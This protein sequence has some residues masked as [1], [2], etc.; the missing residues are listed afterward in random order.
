MGFIPEF[1][2]GNNGNSIRLFVTQLFAMT[3][4]YAICMAGSSMPV[5]FR[6]WVESEKR[7]NA[8][9]KSTIQSELEYLK[10][11]IHPDFLFNVLDKSVQLTQKSPER[12]STILMKLSKLLR[13][14]LY[15]STRDI[16]LLTAE[17]MFLRDFLDLEKDRRNGNGFSFSI[18][19]EGNI[20]QILIPPLLFSPFVEYVTDHI[21]TDEKE[22]F[23]NLTFH[24]E[25]NCLYFTCTGTKSASPVDE[26]GLSDVKRRM[27]LLFPDS[28]SLELMENDRTH[29]VKLE[30]Y[31]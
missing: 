4:T 25:N 14:Q 23:I 5:L 19:T 15:D 7:M 9:E 8:L 13:Y 10:T 31:L 24:V 11:Q 20:N 16:V 21:H 3:F 1:F 6:H 26:T 27:E 29:G 12:A 18:S 22:S 30:L 2:T 28:Y 17:I